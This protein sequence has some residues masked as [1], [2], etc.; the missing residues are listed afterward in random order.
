MCCASLLVARNLAPHTS[1]WTRSAEGTMPSWVS[2]WPFGNSS[3]C[4]ASKLCES[5]RVV[6]SRLIVLACPNITCN[7]WHSNMRIAAC[8]LV[9]L[10]LVEW[11]ARDAFLLQHSI[12]QL[13]LHTQMRKK[14]LAIIK[15]LLA[16]KAPSMKGLHINKGPR[17]SSPTYILSLYM[18]EN[19]DWAKSSWKCLQ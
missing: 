6:G 14:R 11:N 12:D 8:K 4:L 3:K 13:M 1:H 17:Q 5:T 9:Y 2:V 7:Q 16:R 10:N 18:C 19:R 15:C